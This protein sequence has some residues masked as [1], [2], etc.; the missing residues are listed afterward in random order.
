MTQIKVPSD[1]KREIEIFST[2]TNRTQAELVADAWREYRARHNSEF[3]EGLRRAEEILADP[4]ATA[5]SASGMT[6]EEIEKLDDAFNKEIADQP[7]AGST[8][9]PRSRKRKT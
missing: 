9:S 8:V 1:I 6:R 5:V 7:E 3:R 2:L 4:E